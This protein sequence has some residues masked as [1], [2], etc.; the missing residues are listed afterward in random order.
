VSL[1][2]VTATGRRWVT[3]QT[4]Q[5][6]WGWAAHREA[7]CRASSCRDSGEG[8]AVVVAVVAGAVVAEAVVVVGAMV[9]AEQVLGGNRASRVVAG[10]VAGVEAEAEVQEDSTK[11]SAAER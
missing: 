2:Y 10:E 4:T 6:R 5:T 11:S 3:L 1:P 7:V 9:V 8:V